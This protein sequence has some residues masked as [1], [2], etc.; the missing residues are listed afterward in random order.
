ML[1]VLWQPEGIAGMWQ[2]WRR[3]AQPSAAAA[4]PA[5]TVI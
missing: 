4:T 1:M 5:P 2:A 3:R